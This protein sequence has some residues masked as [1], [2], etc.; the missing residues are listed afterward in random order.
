MQ[1]ARR[2]KPRANPLARLLRLPRARTLAAALPFLALLALEVAPLQAW[3]DMY[4]TTQQGGNPQPAAPFA[5]TLVIFALFA[6]A[7]RLSSRFGVAAVVG[8]WLLAACI[9]LVAVIRFSPWMFGGSTEPLY[10]VDW[11]GALATG[12]F[13]PSPI[14]PLLALVAYVGWRGT[15]IGGPAPAISRVSRRFAIGLSALVLAIFGSLATQSGFKGQVD[16]A[17]LALLALEGFAGMAA[18]AMARTRA[19]AGQTGTR[20]PGADYSGRW[21]VAAVGIAFVVMLVV[22]LIGALL[23]LS[24]VKSLIVALAPVGDGINVVLYWIVYSYAYVLYL[25]SVAWASLFISPDRSNHP[26]KLPQPM[27]GPQTSRLPQFLQAVVG[28]AAAVGLIVAVLITV[29]LVVIYAIRTARGATKTLVDEEIEEERE[30]LD[31]ASLLRQQARDR[32]K[33]WR[34]RRPVREHDDLRRDGMRAHYRQ[35]MRAGADLG[36]ERQPNETA[37]EYADRLGAAIGARNR[38]LGVIA[39]QQMRELAVAYDEARYGA[40]DPDPPAPSEVGARARMMAEQLESLNPA[41]A[42]ARR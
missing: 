2:A 15:V 26:I 7:R 4:P 36:Y 32:L 19:D 20:M 40:D 16:G 27:P 23:N 14:A 41:A 42:R 5:M 24:G 9:A 39:Q 29:L 34:R 13:D 30:G 3:L 10:S 12:N 37:D 31:A 11:F 1:T 33:G 6:L 18:L 35:I 8:A 21:Q 17:L 38:K 25:L 28:E 22:T